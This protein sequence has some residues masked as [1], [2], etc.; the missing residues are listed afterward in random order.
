[1]IELRSDTFTLPTQEMLAAA[2]TAPLG[3]DVWGEDPTV[4]RLEQ[5]S[6]EL[7][8]KES[9]LFVTSGTM[10]NLL[11]LLS[12]TRR[13]DE[14][15]A[16]DKSHIVNAEAAGSAVVGGLQLRTLANTR[17]GTLNVDELQAAIRPVDVHYPRTALICL[18]NSHN[19][20]G[21]AVFGR[22]YLGRVRGV[23]DHAG[24]AVHLDGARIFNAAVSLGLRTADLVADADSVTFCLSKGLSAPVGSVL[25]GRAGFIDRARKYRKMLGGGMRQ[26]GVIAA[27]GIVALDTMI[28]RLAEDHRH[29]RR[30]GEALN[31]IPGITVDL[32]TLATNIVV[33][34]LEP[35]GL[36]AADAVAR[37]EDV[38]VKIA[39]VGER[40]IRLVTHR[41]V[42]SADVDG[43]IDAFEQVFQAQALASA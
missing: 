31:R 10:G 29:A 39:A 42:S 20:C 40:K 2:A 4:T 8:G 16:G 13:G 1:M 24:V 32:E 14:V 35:T 6:A 37:L 41:N 33:A 21:G 17:D 19:Q 3:D 26:A 12:Q 22:E 25:C 43:A 23:A 30:L 36:G 18:E 34:E 5:K 28:G 9:A 7:L 15:I 38:G 11:A 27:P